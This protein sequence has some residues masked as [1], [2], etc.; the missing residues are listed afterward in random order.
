[1]TKYGTNPKFKLL[2]QR[3]NLDRKSCFLEGVNLDEKSPKKRGSISMKNRGV[4]FKEK[5]WGHLRRKEGGQFDWILHI[6]FSLFH[7]YLQFAFFLVF[8]GFKLE[9][10]FFLNPPQ[11]NI[12]KEILPTPFMHF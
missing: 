10:R 4:S 2:F 7:P 3:V 5:A 9:T 6:G 12:G 1:M 11:N 8:F